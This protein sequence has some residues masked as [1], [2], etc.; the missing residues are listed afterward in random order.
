MTVWDDLVGQ[1]GP[2]EVLQAAVRGAARVLAGERVAG[3]AHAWLFTGPPG[4]GRST[5]ARAFA[6]ALQC[7][8]GGCGRCHGCTTVLAGSH[9][10]LTVVATEATIIKV[11]E[12][13]ALIEV[14]QRRPSLR[15]W[16]VVL[17]EDADRLNDQGAN[18]LLKA[19][20]E[21]PPRTVWMLCAPSPQ[22]VLITI[23]SRCRSV[24]LRLPP[25]DAVAE[26][27]VRR[28]GVDPA[29]AAYAARA[30]Q[31]HIGRAL[32]LAR[33]EGARMR[34]R[35]VLDLAFAVRG[36][37][38]AVLRAGQLVEV[39]NE[40][41]AAASLDRDAGERSALLR[42]L[43][44]EGESRLPPSVRSQV[45]DLE[46]DQR[47]R[48]QRLKRDVIDQALLDLL[49]V[50]RDV[51]VLHLGA[52]VDLVNGSERTR[53]AAL[54]RS[55][56]PEEVLRRMDAIGVTRERLT[57]NANPLLVVEAM[58]LQLVPADA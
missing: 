58:A 1:A 36:V 21:P 20:E 23:R 37:G 14:A 5:A 47:R 24:Q 18:A 50:Y 55:T 46:D 15:R 52:D 17:V 51:L 32:R 35:E 54:V 43:G 19:I 13:R 4:S 26:L 27:L 10:D 7:E 22:D 11:S 56:T 3:T 45:K 42:A 44:F 12:A 53:L 6:A 34:R 39:A 41:S 28:N 57:T 49:S 16:R 25:V 33:D 48:G 2:V 31:S 8:Q 40:E 9:P 38:D 30:A 29:M